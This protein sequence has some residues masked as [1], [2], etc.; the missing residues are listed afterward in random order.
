[1]SSTRWSPPTSHPAFFWSIG[2]LQGAG[3]VADP[4]SEFIEMVPQIRRVLVHA[5]GAGPLE[6]VDAVSA[7]QHADAQSP[8]TSRREQVPNAVA[9][10]DRIGDVHPQL[11]SRGEE[12]IGIRLGAWDHVACDDR[13]IRRDAQEI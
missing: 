7:R 2:R 3:L 5:V 1:M 13:P 8:R 12:E 9:N 11:F 10:H 6:L 4:D